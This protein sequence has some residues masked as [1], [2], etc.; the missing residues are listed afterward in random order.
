MALPDQFVLASFQGIPHLG[1][2]GGL[3]ERTSIAAD[4]LPVEPS[5]AVARHLAVDIVSGEDTH[6][7]PTAM[8]GIVSLGAGLEPVRDS[9][10]VSV[11]PL[12]DASAAQCAIIAAPTLA[13]HG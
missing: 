10:A 11:D 9:P 6:T 7:R 2:E 3:G 5:R 8:T 1:A 4:Q 12:D 13:R